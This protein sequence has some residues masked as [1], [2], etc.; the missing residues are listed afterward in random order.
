MKFKSFVIALVFFCSASFAF[1]SAGIGA[2]FS[3]CFS[4]VPTGLVSFTARSD[5]SPWC[6]FF[7]AHREKTTVTA[8]V[9]NW[10]INEHLTDSVDYY[11]LWGLSVGATF[12][13]DEQLL[14]TGS[15]LG[16]GLDF[17]LL[18]R[19]LELFTQAVCEPYYGARKTDG[20]WR[21]F[22]RPVNFPC[23][24]GFRLWF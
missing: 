4:T 11:L 24:A 10:F 19:R 9:D 20:R 17:F 15:R 18:G 3:E 1:S 6:V 5:V 2:S 16:L 14:A 7:N 23:S 13:D 8:F 21:P 22:I 12:D